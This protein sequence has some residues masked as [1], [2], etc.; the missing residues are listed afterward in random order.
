MTKRIQYQ[1]HKYKP[2]QTEIIDFH[3]AIDYDYDHGVLI[4][5]SWQLLELYSSA[6]PTPMNRRLAISMNH[7]YKYWVRIFIRD[8]YRL[9]EA[10]SLAMP[11]PIGIWSISMNS[12]ELATCICFPTPLNDTM[13]DGRLWSTE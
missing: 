4:V 10:A 11:G 7:K 3:M 5:L 1:L 9:T 13:A 6:D 8:E 2:R 12:F